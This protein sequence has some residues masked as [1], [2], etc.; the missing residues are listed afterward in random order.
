MPII[1]NSPLRKRNDG[2]RVVLKLK[3]LS[4]QWWT[5]STVS[6]LKLLTSSLRSCMV[7]AVSAATGRDRIAPTRMFVYR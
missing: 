6:S 7:C 1:V 2:L 5:D 3:R 4:V